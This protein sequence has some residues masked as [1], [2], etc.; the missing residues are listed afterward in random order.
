M[1][2]FSK[3]FGS[4]EA[5]KDLND[6][7]HQIRAAGDSAAWIGQN[8]CLYRLCRGVVFPDLGN[9]SALANREGAI[10]KFAVTK[11]MLRQG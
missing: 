1:M 2:T 7:L 11:S 9:P 4:L 10:K 8:L 3:P 6:A 5:G